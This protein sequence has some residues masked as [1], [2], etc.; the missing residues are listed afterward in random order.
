M[1]VQYQV[2]ELKKAHQ[3]W[4]RSVVEIERHKEALIK[5][6]RVEED[7]VTVAPKR[8]GKFWKVF[9]LVL[10]NRKPEFED[11]TSATSKTMPRHNRK[12]TVYPFF[13]SRFSQSE[14]VQ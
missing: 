12:K 10:N 8:G 6:V 5:F 3:E 11:T 2:R 1:A 4:V 7:G 14:G 13:I 9:Q